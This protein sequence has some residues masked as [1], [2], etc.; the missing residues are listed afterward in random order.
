MDLK[1]KDGMI[2]IA[3]ADLDR[4]HAIRNLFKRYRNTVAVMVRFQ[5]EQKPITNLLSKMWCISDEILLK[6]GKIGGCEDEGNH[7]EDTGS[8]R[9]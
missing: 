9:R 8:V 6:I 2:L 3:Q 1:T 4:L 7:S 5:S